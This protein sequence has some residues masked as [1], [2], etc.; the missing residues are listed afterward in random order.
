MPATGAARYWG[1]VVGMES[2][3]QVRRRLSRPAYGL[4]VLIIFAVVLGGCTS[5]GKLSAIPKNAPCSFGGLVLVP[6][7]CIRAQPARHPDGTWTYPAS[8]PAAAELHP[9]SILVVARTSVRRVESV[10]RT[11][12]R[13]ALT[14]AAVP[15]TEVIKDGVIP[16]NASITPH[17]VK[18][19]VDQPPPPPPPEP[20]QAPI[21]PT[22]SPSHVSPSSPVTPVIS[23]SV[24]VIRH[25]YTGF[26]SGTAADQWPAF[27]ATIS[28][29][30]GPVT[31]AYHWTLTDPK[32][33]PTPI[34]GTLTFP[35]TGP[36]TQ[37][38]DYSVPVNQ[39]VPGTTNNGDISLQVDSPRMA[40][41][42]GQLPYVV[43]CQPVVQSPTDTSTASPGPSTGIAVSGSRLGSHQPAR[44]LAS[45]AQAG[46]DYQIEPSLAL[47][48]D[49]F[50]VDVVAT[51][52]VGPA[53]LTWKVHGELQDFLS[54]GGLRI[55]D[56]QLR[57]SGLD[58]TRLRGQLRFDWIL[59]A[60]VPQAVLDRFS[61]DLPIRLF[62][63][64]LP[65]G[66]FPVFLAVEIHLHVGPEFT[67]GQALHGYASVSFSGGQGLGI[68]LHAIDQPKGLSI[69][70]L[71]L[72]PG[73]RDLMKLPTLKAG[74]E[75]P[76]LRLGD[77]FYSTGAWLW[78]SPEIEIGIAPGHDPGPCVRAE[79]DASASVGT[80]FE[81][82]GLREPLSTQIFD[83]PLPSAVSFPQNPECI[84]G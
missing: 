45:A 44:L 19:T 11:G 26:C 12:D 28:V 49:S 6:V 48:K 66:D 39:Y 84:T 35:G 58:A 72:D 77:D 52:Q 40:A 59:S 80:E 30:A 15:L 14:T 23:V 76:Y 81:L 75:F 1:D 29:S 7:V 47:S 3:V 33:T 68:H 20:L 67:P 32:G 74:V 83:R 2:V 69:G 46:N 18:K 38:T 55:V 36:Q 71:H 16:L 56:H 4:V 42:P 65:V 37:T 43:N 5:G 24:R 78:T 9:G 82:F 22:P 21:P 64:P 17:N 54:A 62:V 73:I 57:D 31:V 63:V 10:L 53:K 60:A 51:H 79:T 50:L 25:T 70:G 13:V 34:P 41:I 61:L 27:R 8:N